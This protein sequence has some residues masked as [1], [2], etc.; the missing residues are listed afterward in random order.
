MKYDYIFTY[1]AQM[2]NVSFQLIVYDHIKFILIIDIVELISLY[3]F[4]GL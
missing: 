2:V 3:K 1:A 4:K